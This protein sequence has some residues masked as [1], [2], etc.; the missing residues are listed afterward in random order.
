MTLTPGTTVKNLAVGSARNAPRSL[1]LLVDGATVTGKLSAFLGFGEARVIN[2]ALRLSDAVIDSSYSIYA[3]NV[4]NTGSALASASS[5]CHVSRPAAT[6][7]AASASAASAAAS[8]PNSA[9]IQSTGGEVVVT[10]RGWAPP[11]R[12]LEAPPPR[13]QPRLL[14]S[15]AQ[16]LSQL[17]GT[18]YGDR[19]SG[20]AGYLTID[21][22][23]SAGVPE[24]RFICECGTP[25]P[26]AR[27]LFSDA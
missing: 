24:F 16:R 19:S 21:V 7:S 14:S 18:R 15:D 3:L 23:G 26:N 20:G 22:V 13:P 9:H 8:A 1:G 11:P 10:Q 5:G 6:T 4:S 27:L 25:H 17:Y 12:N 2:S